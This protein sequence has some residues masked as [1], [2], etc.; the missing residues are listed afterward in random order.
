[1]T[2]IV[3]TFLD[4]VQI[5]SPSGNERE[6][7]LYIQKKLS[8]LGMNPLVDSVGNLI[9]KIHGSGLPLLLSAHM[10]TVNPGK[11]IK[12]IIKNGVISPSTN[13]IL[14]ADNK[15][16]IAAILER[17]EQISKEKKNSRSLEIIFT[18]SEETKMIGSW[19]LDYKTITSKEGYTFDIAEP[20]G[21]IV[22]SSPFYNRFTVKILGKASHPSKPEE[23]INA[24]AIFND[25]YRLLGIGK[26]INDTLSNIGIVTSGVSR[27]TIPGEAIIEGEV[28]SYS[29][30]GLED[31]TEDIRS[32]FEKEAKFQN[33][34]I[35]FNKTRENSGY[36]Y[37]RN[38]PRIINTKK[39]MKQIGI[40]PRIIATWSISDSNIFQEHGINMLDLGNGIKNPHTQNE[41]VT[42][43]NLEKLLLLLTNLTN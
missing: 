4:L 28:R 29:E 16:A 17:L 42:I 40:Y 32:L 19:G 20:I 2:N 3:K 33:G 6:V 22:K 5:D 7:S 14:G 39:I 43:K 35:V 12:P 10:D 37:E 34:S 25:T 18:I 1:M 27:N 23:A 30:K 15:V 8:S 36:S 41:S 24:L 11:N 26:I 38:N 9:V 21:T 31:A 13:T